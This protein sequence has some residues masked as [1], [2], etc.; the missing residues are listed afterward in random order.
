[1]S[2]PYCT[3]RRGSDGN[4]EMCG[5]PM[6]QCGRYHSRGTCTECARVSPPHTESAVEILGAIP[7][8][9]ERCWTPPPPRILMSGGQWGPDATEADRARLQANLA[10]V[11]YVE[12][13]LAVR[14][15]A[16]CL[17]ARKNPACTPVRPT[18]MRARVRERLVG[19]RGRLDNI[20][21][22]LCREALAKHGSQQAAAESLGIS[23][24]CL[25]GRLKEGH[26]P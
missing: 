10:P 24:R 26:R 9:G 17:V 1:M 3:G 15:W 16:A 19:D 4:C 8:A 23:R 22:E 20:T 21:T 14:D 11:A 25:A 18:W 2:N 7:Y 6:C 12:K 13:R 5:V